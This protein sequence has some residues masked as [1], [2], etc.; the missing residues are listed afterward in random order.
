MSASAGVIPTSHH[1]QWSRVSFMINNEKGQ[2][3]P[4]T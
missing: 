3:S 2:L 1:M 4:K